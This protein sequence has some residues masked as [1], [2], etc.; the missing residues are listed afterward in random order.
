[1]TTYKARSTPLQWR[2][3]LESFAEDKPRENDIPAKF[4]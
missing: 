2:L 4:S 3:Q 1:M